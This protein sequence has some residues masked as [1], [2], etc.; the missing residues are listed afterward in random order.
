MDLAA[1]A[2]HAATSFFIVTENKCIK[3]YKSTVEN[4]REGAKPE[5]GHT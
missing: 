2:I 3:S 5:T 4:G 1:S